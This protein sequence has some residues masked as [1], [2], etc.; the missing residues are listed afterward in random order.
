M[1]HLAADDCIFTIL[2]NTLSCMLHCEVS[3]VLVFPLNL[4]AKR[5]SRMG[6]VIKSFLHYFANQ[7][8]ISIS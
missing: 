8:T 7:L 1:Y 6:K 2:A 5:Y 4:I 3:Q